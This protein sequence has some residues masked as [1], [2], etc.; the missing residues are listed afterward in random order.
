[1][2]VVL[3]YCPTRHYLR[4]AIDGRMLCLGLFWL[5]V[6]SRW[7]WLWEELSVFGSKFYSWEVIVACHAVLINQAVCTSWIRNQ[8]RPQGACPANYQRHLWAVCRSI[9]WIDLF[10]DMNRGSL[11]ANFQLVLR[12]SWI[13]KPYGTEPQSMGCIN[14]MNWCSF[15]RVHTVDSRNKLTL[16]I[17]SIWPGY[18]ERF[19]Q[20][21]TPAIR[22]E[23]N[24]SSIQCN[25]RRRDSSRM[26]SPSFTVT[27]LGIAVT[28]YIP[29]IEIG[30]GG[31]YCCQLCCSVLAIRDLQKS[32]RTLLTVYVST[33][34]GL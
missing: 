23:I 7:R 13:L 5:Y 20:V 18:G 19:A 11:P 24:R 9:L 32:N 1:M 14:G 6:T 31:Q 15:L 17:H 30:R 34:I 10:L 8:N 4:L 28:L 26:I 22:V 33:L 16:Q 29:T 3:L 2:E 21:Q 25:V 27:E 12:R